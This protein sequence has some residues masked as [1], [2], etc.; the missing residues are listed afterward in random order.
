M[1]AIGIMTAVVALIAPAPANAQTPEKAET[2]IVMDF[3]FQGIHIPFARAV[4]GG[5]YA[6]EGLKVT[7]DRGYGSGDTVTKVAS[8]T[9]DFGFA[10][11]N[12]LV[13]FNTDHPESRVISVFQAFDRSL[14]ALISL[15]SNGITKP[16]DFAGKLLAGSEGEGS[17]L[18]FPV[19]ARL[20][21]FDG[22]S[23][24]WLTVASNLREA[25]VVKKQAQGMAGFASTAFFNL[26][27]AG[28]PVDDIAVFP[29][30]DYGLDLYGNTVVVREDFAAQNPATV[31]ALVRGTIAGMQDAMKNPAR[32]IASLKT[33]DP[34]MNDT[35][36]LDRYKYV[37]QHAIETDNVR[38]NGL[39]AI[40]KARWARSIA[41]VAEVF[42]V[43]TP[44]TPDQIA[45]DKFLPPKDK[46]ML[47]Q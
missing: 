36:E 10:D 21:G 15:K 39:G 35:L 12:A 32:G 46:R 9:Y 25:M 41:V 34:L 24:K 37:A 17:R 29:Y 38:K 13:K 20:A 43:K 18:L 47:A 45:T 2:K 26:K 23:V 14:A 11:A 33:R 22:S 3:A 8:R 44:P 4:D 28:A 5:Y 1:K 31:A 42:G 27:A 7:L 6:K 30:A 19:F 40:D 16:A